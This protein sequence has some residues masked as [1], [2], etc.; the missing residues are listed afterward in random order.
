M[1][2]LVLWTLGLGFLGSTGWM[3]AEWFAPGLQFTSGPLW[4]R[5]LLLHAITGHML[6][7]SAAIL[8]GERLG[9]RWLSALG[10]LGLALQLLMTAYIFA[11]GIP[12]ETLFEAYA[13]A[14][15]DPTTAD[16]LAY[17]VI[18]MLPRL[19]FLLTLI[20]WVRSMAHHG[21]VFTAA[22]SLCFI[23][24]IVLLITTYWGDWQIPKTLADTQ[25]ITA[26]SHSSLY[27]PLL[28]ALPAFI[29]PATTRARLMPLAWTGGAATTFLVAAIF[30]WGLGYQGMPTGYADFSDT[31][32]NGARQV[33]TLS[34][35]TL[36]L[37][38]IALWK[39]RR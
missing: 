15:P 30:L 29:L 38:L 22:M 6:A 2:N 16:R 39:H 28:L 18:V 3:L 32:K 33:V 20:I 1:G 24:L 34:V 7:G 5:I 31:Y 9:M 14:A 27:V 19:L 8:A 36:L 13:A 12:G 26:L 17:Y 37:W 25:V 11:N 4:P 23:G 35:T 10:W 21:L